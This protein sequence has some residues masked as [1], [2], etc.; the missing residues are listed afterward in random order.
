M[1]ISEVGMYV[2]TINQEQNLADKQRKSIS[3]VPFWVVLIL[4]STLPC[5]QVTVD[6]AVHYYKWTRRKY[7]SSLFKAMKFILDEISPQIQK[8]IDDRYNSIPIVAA[9]DLTEI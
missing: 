6:H 8:R 1:Y 4:L 2:E 7:Q 3:N 5:S 9:V